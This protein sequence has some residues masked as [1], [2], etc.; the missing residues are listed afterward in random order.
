[1]ARVGVILSAQTLHNLLTDRNIEPYDR[2]LYKV[3]LYLDA[4]RSAK[5]SRKPKGRAA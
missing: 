4:V 2:T 1:M 5:P 3:G